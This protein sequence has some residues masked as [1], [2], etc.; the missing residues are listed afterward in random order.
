MSWCMP[1]I[2]VRRVIDDGIKR[3]RLNKPA[4]IDIFSDFAKDELASEYGAAYAEEIWL[5][6]S[7]TKIPVIQSWSFNAQKI[8]SISVHLAN[9]QE[10]E[11]KIAFDDYGGTFED[12]VTTTGTAAFTVML[13]IGIHANKGGDHVLW[14]Y[15]ILSYVLF[16]NKPDLVRLG[17]KMGTFSASDYSKD[18]EK[19][20]NNIWTRVIRYRCTTQSAWPADDLK[21]IEKIDLDAKGGINSDDFAASLDVDLTTVDTSQS[22]GIKVSR[23]GDIDGDDDLGA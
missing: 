16:K 4:F 5:W 11:D 12:D 17:L 23:I 2:V 13:D 9:E 3:L 6:F 15:Y 22:E 8:P 7:T 19:M 14:L 18:V 10:A 20:G 21:E 1:E